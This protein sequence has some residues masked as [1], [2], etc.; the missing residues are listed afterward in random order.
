M[1]LGLLLW[2]REVLLKRLHLY[3]YA[4]LCISLFWDQLLIRALFVLPVF[5]F[6]LLRMKSLCFDGLCNNC[7]VS[8]RW[9]KLSITP[10]MIPCGEKY[11]PPRLS[12]ESGTDNDR[13]GVEGGMINVRVNEANSWEGEITLWIRVLWRLGCWYIIHRRGHLTQHRNSKGIRLILA[14]VNA[15]TFTGFSF[16]RLENVAGFRRFPANFQQILQISAGSSDF[17]LTCPLYTS[18][19]PFLSSL[20]ASA[21]KSQKMSTTE[22]NA[23][24]PYVTFN[25]LV[26]S[27][28]ETYSKLAPLYQVRSFLLF[29]TKRS[30]DSLPVV[31][32]YSI[33]S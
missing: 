29:M 13:I 7:L 8:P 17:N 28:S 27:Q 30:S 2:T 23:V 5:A 20:Q 15:I 10:L 24:T 3:M 14:L 32:D 25:N 26:K 4:W 22:E 19:T 12:R 31:M 6:F 11:V 21:G 16:F 1:R 18:S 9:E 33:I